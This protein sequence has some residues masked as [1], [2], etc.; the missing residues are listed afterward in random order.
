MCNIRMVSCS[1]EYTHQTLIHKRIDNL[2]EGK[3]NNPFIELS[4]M[5]A[6]LPHRFLHTPSGAEKQTEVEYSFG[7]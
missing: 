2:P 7:F 4:W 5:G 6:F 3:K 1:S